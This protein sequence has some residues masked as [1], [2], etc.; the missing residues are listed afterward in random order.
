[1]ATV[2][3]VQASV[4]AAS[5]R[6]LVASDEFLKRRA[7]VGWI[8]RIILFRRGISVFITAAIVY[9]LVTIPSCSQEVSSSIFSPIPN[10]R[11]FRQAGRHHHVGVGT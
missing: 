9:I 6:R 11:R 5:P 1:M 4:R 7:I 10:G 3:L 2:E 8:V